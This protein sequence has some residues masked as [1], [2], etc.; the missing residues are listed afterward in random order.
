MAK[1]KRAD[2]K[3]AAGDSSTAA[4]PARRRFRVSLQH[5][6]TLDVDAANQDQAWQRY[7]QARGIICSDH[8]HRLRSQMA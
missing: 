3:P 6:A 8:H 4:K 2:T 5:E 7:R 1:R